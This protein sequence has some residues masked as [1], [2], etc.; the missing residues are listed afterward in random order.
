MVQQIKQNTFDRGV[1]FLCILYNADMKNNIVTILNTVSIILCVL[2][3]GYYVL[4]SWAGGFNTTTGRVTSG[5]DVV[6]IVFII[7]TTAVCVVLSRTIPSY[8]ILFSA[9]PLVVMVGGLFVLYTTLFIAKRNTTQQNQIQLQNFSKDFMHKDY[10]VNNEFK[11]SGSDSFVSVD[12]KNQT[13][14]KVYV[15]NNRINDSFEF[16]RIVNNGSGAVLLEGFNTKQ[17]ISELKDYI[18]KDGVSV[19]DFYKIKI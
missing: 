18:N 4:S 2:L 1:L 9:L 14:I 11:Q 13:L 3:I 5:R 15:E 6:V 7:I 19:L 10:Y 16:A 8:K 12:N 17:Y